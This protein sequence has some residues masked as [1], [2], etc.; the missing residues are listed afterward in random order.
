L[1]L[2]ALS[3]FSTICILQGTSR[4]L[5]RIL[6]LITFLHLVQRV[7]DLKKDEAANSRTVRFAAKE[8]GYFM[9]TLFPA[10]AQATRPTVNNIT[11]NMINLCFPRF[12]DQ[13]EIN[14]GVLD[15]CLTVA[16]QLTS[17]SA[18]RPGG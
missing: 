1:L 9:A 8:V 4:R 15:R 18:R 11:H 10:K 12:P 14:G 16:Q 6:L 13:N 3:L 7:L 17:T 5:T 2:K